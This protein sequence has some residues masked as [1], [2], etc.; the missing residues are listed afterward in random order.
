MSSRRAR[1]QDRDP[2]R[3]EG[4]GDDR[5]ARAVQGS[6]PIRSRTASSARSPPTCP[7]A[8]D[9]R[10]ARSPRASQP[11]GERD[12]GRPARSHKAERLRRVGGRV[13]EPRRCPG[14]LFI[15]QISGGEA[16]GQVTY[17]EMFN[18]QPFSNTLVVKTCTGAQIEA[19]LEQQFVVQSRTARPAA[20]GQPR[21][22]Y[23]M[24]RTGGQQGRPRVDQ[25]RRRHREPGRRATA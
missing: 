8:R 21:Y 18:V 10:A 5:P 13:H 1:Q 12:R 4:P 6:S 19:L 14:R 11:M 16:P 23:T 2:E 7:S 25:D 17:G 24:Q 22:T 9:T 20:A 15:N 3:R